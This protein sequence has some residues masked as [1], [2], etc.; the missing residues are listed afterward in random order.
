MSNGL[1]KNHS[2]SIQG[3]AIL[4]MLY[5]HFF[6]NPQAV[7]G[8]FYGNISATMHVAWFGKICVGLFCFVSGYGMYHVCTHCSHNS[9]SRL[10]K[11]EYSACLIRIVKLFIRLWAVILIVKGFSFLFLGK[12][13]DITEFVLNMLTIRLTYNGSWWFI[14]LYVVM[15]LALPFL[16]L[17]FTSLPVRKERTIKWLLLSAL[18]ALVIGLFCYGTFHS[19]ESR[20]ILYLI[21]SSLPP[22]FL[23]IFAIGYLFARFAIY[24]KLLHHLNR[25][26]DRIILPSALLCLSG[27]ILLR[28]LLTKDA[29]FA[30]L[31]FLFVPLFIF[32]MIP[33]INHCKTL[34]DILI[35]FGKISTYLWLVHVL[36]YD[37]TVDLFAEWFAPYGGMP[38]SAFYLAQLFLSGMIALLFTT[39]EAAFS[40]GVFSKKPHKQA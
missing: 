27:T 30:T 12:P 1:T 35:F 3:L 29:S 20:Y 13:F 23:L 28:V 16:D 38:S 24:E 17:F 36:I 14:R 26:S 40:R 2:S 31:D 5:H 25:L 15:L 37:V 6:L 11:E 9:L 19:P 34:S 32:G 7:P 33:L 8:I 22:V 18:S 39:A 21:K 4:L 10:L